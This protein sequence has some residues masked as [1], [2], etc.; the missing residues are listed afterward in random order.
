TDM[1]LF[2]FVVLGGAAGT[3][4][5]YLLGVSVQAAFGPTFPMGTLSVNLI[6]SFFVSMFM[7][8]GADKGLIS[9]PTRVVLCTGVMGGFTTYSSFNFETMRLAQA[10]SFGLALLNVG[11]TVVGCLVAGALGLLTGRLMGGA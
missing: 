9:T 7:V 1:A 4:A 3:A 5:R 2:L 11:A 6:G 10:G 8:L